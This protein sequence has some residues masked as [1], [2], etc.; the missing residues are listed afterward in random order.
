LAAKSMGG[1]PR[2][3]ATPTCVSGLMTEDVEEELSRSSQRRKEE[4]IK[5]MLGNR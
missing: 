1:L 4:N 3:V 2:E 5:A